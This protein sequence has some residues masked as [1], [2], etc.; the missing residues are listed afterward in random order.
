M[1]YWTDFD[2]GDLWTLLSLLQFSFY[3][4]AIIDC[5]ME[6]KSAKRAKVNESPKN[7]KLGGR[8]LQ[9]SPL[10]KPVDILHQIGIIF[11]NSLYRL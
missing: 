10:G 2:N 8:G 5:E 9:I 6:A 1:K 11:R 4:K 7:C 3:I